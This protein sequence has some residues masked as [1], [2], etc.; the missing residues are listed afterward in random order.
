MIGGV[1]QSFL[2]TGQQLWLLQFSRCPKSWR[3]DLLHGEVLRPCRSALARVGLQPLLGGGTLV[4]VQPSAMG[5]VIYALSFYLAMTFGSLKGSE[6][7]C[8]CEFKPLVL[9]VTE[10]RPC[11][12]H[13]HLA[14]SHI[15]PLQLTSPLLASTAVRN[16]EACPG[17]EVVV[18]GTFL[19]VGI[20]TACQKS[21][22]STTDAHLGRNK[23]P[24]VRDFECPE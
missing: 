23:N 14:K 7:I 20:R 13:V 1:H 17:P 11:K 19:H 3:Q 10:R 8:S 9:A 5:Y 12:E 15:L 24:R 16:S 22:A 4:F 21:T 18:R 2:P 6:V